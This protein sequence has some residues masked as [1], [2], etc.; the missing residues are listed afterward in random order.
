MKVDESINEELQIYTRAKSKEKE[1]K[2]DVLE[3]GTT[4]LKLGM[5]F[6]QI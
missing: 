1:W 6:L 3:W 2:N 4:T 5:G